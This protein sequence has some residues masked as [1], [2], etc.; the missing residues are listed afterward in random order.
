VA[1]KPVYK[2][3]LIAKGFMQSYGVNFTETW[4]PTAAARSVRLVISI[5]AMRNDRIRH[6]DIKSA[7]LN[8][9]LTETVYVQPPT[10]YARTDEVLATLEGPL[11][12]EA[13]WKRV[14]QDVEINVDSLTM[15]S[16]HLGSMR[17]LPSC[18]AILPAYGSACG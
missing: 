4:A 3:R 11:W 15:E 14:V 18:T 7:Y 10:G 2:S 6:I 16:N 8:A 9:K 12:F 5:A 1:G 13:G 17:L